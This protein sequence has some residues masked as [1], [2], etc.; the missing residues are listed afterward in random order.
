MKSGKESPIYERA[1]DN[2][3]SPRKLKEKGLDFFPSEL[4]DI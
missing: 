3:F 2:R 1:R 4:K